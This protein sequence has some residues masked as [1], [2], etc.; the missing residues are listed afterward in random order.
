[1]KLLLNKIL[2]LAGILEFSSAGL[3]EVRIRS[4]EANLYL[5]MNQNGNL[6]GE[7]N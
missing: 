7:V 1:M 2:Q 6:Y 3:G 5:A 4:V